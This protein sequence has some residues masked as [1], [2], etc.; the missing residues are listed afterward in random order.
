MTE[1]SGGFRASANLPASRVAR[2]AFWVFA[3]VAAYFL[4][5]EHRAHLSQA[6][7]WI[8]LSLCPLMHIFMH[9]GHGDHPRSSAGDERGAG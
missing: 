7:P 4:W 6:L 5:T 8:L 3:G 1:N 9:R 2:V